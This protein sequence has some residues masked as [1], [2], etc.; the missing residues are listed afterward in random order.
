[1][2][3]HIIGH[4]KQKVHMY[5]YVCPAPNGFRNRTA[6]QQNFKIINGKEILYDV[7]KANIYFSSDKFRAVSVCSLQC[8]PETPNFSF[9]ALYNMAYYSSIQRGSISGNVR[10]KTLIHVYEHLLCLE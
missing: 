8:F 3:D 6:L 1:V 10:T 7:S 2:G 5:A 4:S 9:H